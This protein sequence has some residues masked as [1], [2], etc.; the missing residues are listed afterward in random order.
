MNVN[1][2]LQNYDLNKDKDYTILENK[3]NDLLEQLEYTDNENEQKKILSKIDEIKELL[4]NAKKK[5]NNKYPSY[6]NK[7][8][9]KKLLTKKEF[10]MNRINSNDQKNI[11]NNFFELSNNQ[12]FL[13]KLISTETPYRTIYLYH[14]VG[15][16][17]TC[18]S[19]QIAHNFKNYYR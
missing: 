7:D 17:K 19:I 5:V 18:A 12:K 16:G 9:I 8:F 3:I 14:S 1:N 11:Q 6:N 4:K 10:A 13:K 2:I 15:V